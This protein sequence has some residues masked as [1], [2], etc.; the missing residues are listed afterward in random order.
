RGNREYLIGACAGY[1]DDALAVR[2]PN[3]KQIVVLKGQPQRLSGSG[4]IVDPNL[5]IIGGPDRQRETPTLRRQP[6]VAREF[7]RLPSNPRD[8]CAAPIDPYEVAAATLAASGHE[9]SG[10]I[11]RRGDTRHAARNLGQHAVLKWNR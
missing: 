3:R 4:E 9:H 7:Q 11:R 10:T 8:V 6:R 2:R 5:A 1:E